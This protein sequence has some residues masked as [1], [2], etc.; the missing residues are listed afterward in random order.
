ML[1][2]CQDEVRVEDPTTAEQTATVADQRCSET[3]EPGGSPHGVVIYFHGGGWRGDT[4]SDC[5]SN[6][7]KAVRPSAAGLLPVGPGPTNEFFASQGWRSVS[8]GYAGTARL[9]AGGARRSVSDALR[10]Y[11]LYADRTELPLCVA[12]DSSGAHIA[13]AVAVE[14]PVDCVVVT[15]APTDLTELVPDTAEV[16]RSPFGRSEEALRRYSPL[17]RVEQI[18]PETPVL[19]GHALCDPIV[20]A[21]QSE[22]FGERR[23]ELAAPALTEVHLME[24]GPQPFT[25]ATA[26]SRGG[27]MGVARDDFRAWTDGIAELLRRVGR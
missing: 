16:V 6:V 1:V 18:P 27:C 2:S 11:D 13:L 24:R 10:W 14:R 8:A 15:G 26:A 19:L 17:L 3:F 9:G 23:G 4:P 5:E 7:T 25:H 22:R 12:G 21:R 20:P